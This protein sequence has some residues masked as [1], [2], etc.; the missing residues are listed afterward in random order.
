MIEGIGSGSVPLT[1]GSGFGSRR[2]KNICIRRIRIRN[3]DSNPIRIHNTVLKCTLG[4][5]GGRWCGRQEGCEDPVGAGRP[6]PHRLRFL[7]P[8][9]A[10]DRHLRDKRP[11][12]IG[13]FQ[14]VTHFFQS[15]LQG[16]GSAFL[17]S[18]SGSSILGWIPI[19]IQGFN[20][21]KLKK[22]YSWKKITFFW[23]KNHNLPIPRLL[24]RYVVFVGVC[25]LNHIFNFRNFLDF[26]FLCTILNTASSAS[27]PIPLCRRMLGSKPGLLRL[28]HWQSDAL[29]TRLDL[30]HP[31]Y[32]SPF[33]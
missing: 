2:P 14:E 11:Q 28:R 23:N 12:A 13:I 8:I 31:I 24:G 6:V 20:D 10:T 1:N 9:R 32:C 18:G 25:I 21:Q 26:F 5:Q 16:C 19:R 22:N 4:F 17:S 7:P 30:I 15:L 3:T 33:F 29:T 27:P